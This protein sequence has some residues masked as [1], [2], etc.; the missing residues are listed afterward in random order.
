MNGDTNAP[1]TPSKL[2]KSTTSIHDDGD[3]DVNGE[4]SSHESPKRRRLKDR[5]VDGGSGSSNGVPPRPRSVAST[6]S[7][8]TGGGGGGDETLLRDLED[9]LEAALGGESD[10]DAAAIAPAASSSGVRAD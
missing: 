2:R 1:R 8:G 5:S 3:E 6:A 10:S 7:N 4:A 9:E